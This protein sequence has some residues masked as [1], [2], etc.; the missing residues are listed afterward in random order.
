MFDEKK[1][2]DSR[3]SLKR[4]M[5]QLSISTGKPKKANSDVIWFDEAQKGNSK[6]RSRKDKLK[7]TPVARTVLDVFP[8]TD[9]PDGV[10]QLRDEAGFFDVYQVETKDVM[11]QNENDTDVDIFSF[12]KLLKAN[13]EDMKIVGLTYPV[14][15]GQQQT[16]HQRKHDKATNPIHEK[17]LQQKIDELSFLQEH[18]TNKELFLFIFGETKQALEDRVVAAK[19]IA[20]IS[21]PLIEL[22]P[23]KKENLLYKMSNQNSKLAMR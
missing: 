14:D 18:R 13:S 19:N 23:S 1:T 9:D 22:S 5:T 12:N 16:F 15:T 6:G 17:F 20:S 3:T 21:F 2:S 11:A 8:I 4:L 7:K 10:F